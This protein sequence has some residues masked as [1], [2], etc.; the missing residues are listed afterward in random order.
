MCLYQNSSKWTNE[1]H[2][3]F[4]KVTYFKKSCCCGHANK[5][6]FVFVSFTSL[7]NI[8]TH[9]PQISQDERSSEG[10]QF[11]NMYDHTQIYDLDC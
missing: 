3:S 1:G 5:T 9:F 6:G 11:Q 7:D 10:Q 8:S 4:E 2:I